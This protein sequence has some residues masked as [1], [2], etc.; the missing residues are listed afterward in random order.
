MTESLY[1]SNKRELSRVLLWV[2]VIIFWLTFWLPS[3]I[4]LGGDA[5]GLGSYFPQMEVVI[6][7]SAVGILL[8]FLSQ[9]ISQ[10]NQP[11][12]FPKL[13][14]GA[15]TAGLWLLIIFIISIFSRDFQTS[16]LFL[17][18]WI[19]GMLA[20]PIAKEFLPSNLNKHI[21]IVMG[22]M[23]GFFLSNIS[24]ELNISANLL[25]LVSAF[26]LVYMSDKIPRNCRSR[27]FI[28]RVFLQI[29]Y[30]FFVFQ[31]NSLAFPLV[32]LFIFIF[33]Q[34]FFILRRG[35][36]SPDFLGIIFFAGFFL[37]RMYYHGMYA[38]QMPM[39]IPHFWSNFR[40]I[41]FGVGQGQF[42]P[43]L[44]QNSDFL[45]P[46]S[47]LEIPNSSFLI[48]FF[49]QGILGVL[50]IILLFIFSY[51]LHRKRSFL[52][53]FLIIFLWVFSSVFSVTENGIILLMLFL[54][55][56]TEKEISRDFSIVENQVWT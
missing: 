51:F 9:F 22:I 50:A 45:L 55:L 38:I 41:L 40:E 19:I 1:V 53:L 30:L 10:Y 17:P 33:S 5:T 24:P 6:P 27:E 16:S 39:T 31:S 56:N 26:G 15:K 37:I 42:L 34:K 47:S 7:I 11:S 13:L 25:A 36:L 48:T 12:Y 43:A 14:R 44:Q 4:F 32:S 54:F 21:L 35:R 49:E 52:Y 18:I 29:F 20:I 23:A 2:G 28:T 46:L 3:G 8:I